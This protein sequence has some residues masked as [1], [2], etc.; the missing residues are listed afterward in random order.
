MG[1]HRTVTTRLA[2]ASVSDP[3]PE[4]DPSG[5]RLADRSSR[6]ER[7]AVRDLLIAA[8]AHDLDRSVVLDHDALVRLP[9]A[10][11]AHR[12]TGT[13]RRALAALDG[14]PDE[15]TAALDGACTTNAL[16]HLGMVGA[17]HE[18]AA[19]LDTAGLSWLAMKGPVLAAH[20]YPDIG[21]RGYSDL[22][23]LVHHRD[24]EAAVRLLEET[25]FEHV[26]RNWPLAERMLAGQVEMRRGPVRIDLHWHLHYARSDRDPYGLRPSAMIARARRVD[27]SG[28]AVPTFD[29]VDTVVTLAFHAARSGG[30]ALVWSKDL[31]RVL[32]VDRPDLDGVVESSRAARCAPAVGLM[33]GRA[34]DLIG[35]PVPDDVVR[36]LVPRPMALADRVVGSVSHPVTIGDGGSLARFFTRSAGPTTARSLAAMPSRAAR[37]LTRHLRPPAVHETDDPHEKASYLRA[38]AAAGDG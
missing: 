24:F 28:V 34:R 19:A 22:D 18:L 38:V 35:A 15:V 10:A 16:T 5:R 11:A 14:V 8:T 17:L 23:L 7:A 33:L 30:H 12:V 37:Q 21:D 31:E 1:V 4:R 32:S 26:I 36:R 25:G 9:A 6:A 20:H 27:V 29:P 2:A 13:V 3:G